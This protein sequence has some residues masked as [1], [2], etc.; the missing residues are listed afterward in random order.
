MSSRLFDSGAKSVP[1][2][3]DD[4]K[5]LL[6]DL[7]RKYGPETIG[8]ALQEVGDARP[9]LMSKRSR[10]HPRGHPGDAIAIWLSVE[11]LTRAAN[12][13]G[14]RL[15]KESACARV[16]RTLA[17]IYP[18]KFRRGLTVGRLR[19]LYYEAWKCIGV[20]SPEARAHIQ[21][22]ADKKAHLFS[23]LQRPEV[24]PFVTRRDG[25]RWKAPIDG[26]S[27]RK[28]GNRVGMIS[29][30]ECGIAIL[31]LYCFTAD[32]NLSDQFTP[33][34]TH[35]QPQQPDVRALAVV[36]RVGSGPATSFIDSHEPPPS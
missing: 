23:K 8:K 21:A 7:A 33:L 15:S 13:A 9:A 11:I 18:P 1:V 20:S 6:M 29:Q 12:L 35:L 36:E 5:S 14:T 34:R 26:R 17:V 19:S 2:L 31:V 27:I 32:P 16:L 24:L 25:D 22:V 3:K 28:L 10:G 30:N 4:D